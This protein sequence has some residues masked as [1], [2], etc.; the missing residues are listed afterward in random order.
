MCKAQM[1]IFLTAWSL[2]KKWVELTYLYMHF[3]VSLG[4]TVGW[5]LNFDFGPSQRSR[6]PR[7]LVVE[8]PLSESD[9]RISEVLSPD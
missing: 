6:F 7:Q 9:I 2:Y 5:P 4:R 3:H 1:V 8:A